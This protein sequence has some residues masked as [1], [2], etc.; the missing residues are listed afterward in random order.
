[1]TTSFRRSSRGV[2][3]S[4]LDECNLQHQKP[5][6]EEADTCTKSILV[7]HLDLEKQDEDSLDSSRARGSSRR[8]GEGWRAKTA[9]QKVS[10][11]MFNHP[12]LDRQV[13][14]SESKV[15]G[16][17]DQRGEEN[18]KAREAAGGVAGAWRGKS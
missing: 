2:S 12:H 7:I 16:C 5:G 8:G 13:G 14:K 11:M 6:Q 15:T 18:K 17:R 1:M 9:L 4:P 10:S 3:F